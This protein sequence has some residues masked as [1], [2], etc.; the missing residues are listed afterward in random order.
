MA[1]TI[2]ESMGATLTSRRIVKGR[3]HNLLVNSEV[4]PFQCYVTI[5]LDSKDKLI[6][7]TTK[8]QNSLLQKCEFDA[9]LIPKTLGYLHK[10]CD[11]FRRQIQTPMTRQLVES[12]D[13]ATGRIEV[14]ERNKE[15][16]D[17]LQLQLETDIKR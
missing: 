15:E 11:Q 4:A 2:S 5:Y 10:L 14:L 16:L 17:R 13:V 7:Y 1:S 6:N 3:I 9:E 12:T 8:A